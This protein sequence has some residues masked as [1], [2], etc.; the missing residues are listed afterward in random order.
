MLER[1][2]FTVL[3]F[4][5]LWVVYGALERAFPARIGRGFREPDFVTDAGFFL[6]QYVVWSAL[7][8]TLL[9]S[10]HGFLDAHAWVGLRSAARQLPPWLLAAVAV[11]LGDLLVYWLH[12]AF[13]HFDLLWRFHAVHHSSERL[14]WLA[15]HREHPVDGVL[16]QTAQNLPAMLLGLPFELLAVLIVFRGA[17]SILIHSN[18]RLPL[19][20]L[21]I[22]FGAPELH[23]FHHARLP[24]TEHNFANLAPWLDVVFGTY[25]C[26]K[27]SEPY[28]LGLSTP[29]P[30]GYVSQLAHPFTLRTRRSEDA[31]SASRALRAAAPR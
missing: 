22:L 24:R 20:P 18:V 31:R 14:D 12:R 4:G 5:G 2:G 29:W 10:L 8:V 3:T 26:P 16:V 13:H 27:D 25:H 21:R 7:A 23:H 9:A 28:P 1:L 19:G 17:W 30:R 11:V 6:G 15:A